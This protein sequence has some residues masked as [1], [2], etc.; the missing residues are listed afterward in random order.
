VIACGLCDREKLTEGE[1]ARH[2]ESANGR[3]KAKRGPFRWA[4]AVD[5]INSENPDGF[6][7]WTVPQV[8]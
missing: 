2:V 5:Y 4:K 7:T 3:L 1:R 8:E 6:H